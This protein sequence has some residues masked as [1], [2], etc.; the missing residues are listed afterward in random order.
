MCV[1]G[2]G[3]SYVQ[4]G[5]PCVGLAMWQSAGYGSP[6]L[7]VHMSQGSTVRP[8]FG[9]PGVFAWVMV[10]YNKCSACVNLI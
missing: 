3:Q 7:G 5:K 8:M 1:V 10:G 9:L 4:P 6:S 2:N